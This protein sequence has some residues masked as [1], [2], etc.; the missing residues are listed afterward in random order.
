[1]TAFNTFNKSQ[2]NTRL[3]ELLRSLLNDRCKVTS[4]TE[5]LEAVQITYQRYKNLSTIDSNILN[6]T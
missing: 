3:N 1:M 2:N 4:L 5:S 6:T